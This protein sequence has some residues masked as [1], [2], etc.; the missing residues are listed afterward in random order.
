M[1][2]RVFDEGQALNQHAD[3]LGNGVVDFDYEAVERRLGES[4]KAEIT[5]T[6]DSKRLK[7][8]LSALLDW[9]FDV[10]LNHFDALRAIGRRAVAMA[11]VIDP[12][13][14]NDDSLRSV[15]KRLG[16]SAPNLA[17]LTAEFSRLYKISNKFQKHD[18]K[19]GKTKFENN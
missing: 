9:Q 17:P 6:C 12:K 8:A 16:F 5:D 14:F 7:F 18:S 2:K 4:P 19:K 15:S 13:R 11:W 3:A 10:D 1:S